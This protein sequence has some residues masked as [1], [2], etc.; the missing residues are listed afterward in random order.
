MEPKREN[1]IKLRFGS[2][3]QNPSN[4]E[5][6]TFFKDQGWTCDDLSAMYRE[7]YCLF[8]RFQ[9]EALVKSALIRL[10]THVDFKYANGEKVR[11]S[12]SLA[13]GMFRYVRIFGLPPEV[14][15]EQIVSVLAKYGTIHQLV[16]ERYPVE[17]GFP[18]WSGIRGAHMEVVTEIPAQ[19]HVQNIR[20][21]VFYEGLQHKCFSCG[22]LDHLKAACPKRRSVNARLEVSAEQDGAA[23]ISSVTGGSKGISSFGE[24]CRQRHHGSTACHVWYGGAK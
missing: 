20:A 7:D 12:V 9:S 13:N 22:A 4:D 19:L 10:G 17:T 15:D 16:R 8:I 24:R 11:V 18:I 1:T 6:F 14:K 21:R 3:T 5:V 23:S 2:H